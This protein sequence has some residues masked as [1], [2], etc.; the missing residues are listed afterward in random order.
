MSTE[1]TVVMSKKEKKREE[2]RKKVF[3]QI[4]SHLQT[5]KKMKSDIDSRKKNEV[6]MLA[7]MGLIS[8][9][10][11]MNRLTRGGRNLGRSC[12]EA[13][14]HVKEVEKRIRGYNVHNVTPLTIDLTGSKYT[15]NH[16]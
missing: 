9:N 13:R 1:W 7:E 11:F 2:D 14:A 4:S 10:T 15:L 8:I 12:F 5:I 16:L 6:R 3:N